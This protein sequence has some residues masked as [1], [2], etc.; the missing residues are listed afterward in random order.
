MVGRTFDLPPCGL[1]LS[2][3][4]QVN[5]MIMFPLP[6]CLTALSA[7]AQLLARRMVPSAIEPRGA[8]GTVERSAIPPGGCVEEGE[9]WEQMPEDLHIKGMH[10]A[11]LTVIALMPSQSCRVASH[12]L[13]KLSAMESWIKSQQ[14]VVTPQRAGGGIDPSYTTGARGPTGDR[15]IHTSYFL[16]NRG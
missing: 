8:V 9:T 5:H 3:L 16:H 7:S 15:V 10:P 13:V 14:A 6:M 1:W 11:Y 2:T 12:A 4:N